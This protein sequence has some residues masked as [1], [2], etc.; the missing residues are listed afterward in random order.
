MCAT[1]R[2]HILQRCR[3]GLSC[4]EPHQIYITILQQLQYTEVIILMVNEALSPTFAWRVGAVNYITT[5][6]PILDST[7]C[8][9]SRKMK[10]SSLKL[11]PLLLLR[12][13]IVLRPH[14]TLDLP[15]DLSSVYMLICWPMCRRSLQL[16]LLEPSCSPSTWFSS[17]ATS[18][19]SRYSQSV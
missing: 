6:S 17:E 12:S 3:R 15:A 9:G 16:C 14:S 2:W 1:L 8:I 18:A 5:P 4:R 11:P 10:Y 7:S 13:N 19:F